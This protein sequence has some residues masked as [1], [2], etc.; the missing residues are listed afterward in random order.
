[1]FTTLLLALALTGPFSIR[2]A[3]DTVKAQRKPA[4][5]P[6]A[7]PAPTAKPAPKPAA[8][9]VGEPVLKRRKPPD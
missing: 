9:A 3:A 1:M 4:S 8:K 2:I 6:V 7:R 5:G